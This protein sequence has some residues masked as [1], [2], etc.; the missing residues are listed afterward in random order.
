MDEKAD[1]YSV[2]KQNERSMQV[3]CGMKNKTEGKPHLI[4]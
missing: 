3:E 4:W 1:T 2:W